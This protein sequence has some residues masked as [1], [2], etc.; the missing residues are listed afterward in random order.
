MIETEMRA[1][2]VREIVFPHPTVSEVL[3]E[4]RAMTM[5][6]KTP[7][8]MGEA[9]EASTSIAGGAATETPAVEESGKSFEE[10]AEGIYGGR[11]GSEDEA[12]DR[13]QAKDVGEG[14]TLDDDGN[15]IDEAKAEAKEKE[16]EAKEVEGKDKDEEKTSKPV[17]KAA[18]DAV[19]ASADDYSF[20]LPEGFVL[21]DDTQSKLGATLHENGV[22][23]GA[24]DSLLGMYAEV[25][26]AEAKAAQQA[27][28]AEVQG[29]R[30]EISKDP[31][32]GGDKAA[33]RDTSIAS[34]LD[35]HGSRELRELLNVSHLGD[36]PAMVKFLRDV[37]RDYA[38]GNFVRGS[39]AP[40]N[41]QDQT[42]GERARG[43]YG[44]SGMNE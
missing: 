11:M 18:A 23:Q 25:R 44:K 19:P 16:P 35:R 22:T 13:E 37:G 28:D 21:D 9:A 1:A 2:D 4:A 14:T 39:S 6:T 42:Y 12:P 24:A 26:Q 3:K 5:M 20:E 40:K 32:L 41:P 38:E 43:I 10:R 31:N 15:P 27:L 33:E 8:L 7:I 29:W 34:V 36:H 17:E 30:D